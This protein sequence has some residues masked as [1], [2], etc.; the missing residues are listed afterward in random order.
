MDD[1]IIR[2]MRNKYKHVIGILTAEQV[3]KTI[4][5]ALPGG[6]G[7]TMDVLGRDAVTGLPS[8]CRVT[9]EDIHEAIAEPWARSSASSSRYWKTH[10]RSW[11]AT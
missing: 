8:V 7:N 11:R 4:G 3:K 9:S 6:V 1:A 2:Y 5:C 10:R